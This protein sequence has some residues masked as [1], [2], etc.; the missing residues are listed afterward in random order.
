MHY[1]YATRSVRQDD[2]WQHR[3]G[4]FYAG[5]LL[6]GWQQLFFRKRWVARRMIFHH[7]PRF[8]AV[9]RRFQLKIKNIFGGFVH[10]TGKSEPL[11]VGERKWVAR[12]V[13]IRL[14]PLKK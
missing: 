9:S 6:N 1:I 10:C 13:K 4:A 14:Y 11:R 2:V 7:F 12:R 8:P 3:D 5:V